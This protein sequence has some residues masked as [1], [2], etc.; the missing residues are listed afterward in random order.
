MNFSVLM[1]VYIKERPEYL[2]SA[3]DSVLKSS[4]T[5]TKIV[6][7]EDGPL[8][9]ELYEVLDSYENVENIKRVPLKKNCGLSV[10][11]NEGIKHIKTDLIARMDT[12]DICREDRFYI[13][14]KEF[15]KHPNLMVLGSDVDEFV[16]GPD[17][18]ISEKNMP[19]G[20][21]EI[22][23]YFKLR[24][25]L[26]HPSV[27]MKSQAVKEV[28][29]YVD[30]PLFE[31]YY[32]W[33]RIIKKYGLNSINNINE[34]LVSMRVVDDLY[35]RRGGLSYAKKSYNFRKTAIKEKLVPPIS[36]FAALISTS[37]VAIMPNLFRKRIYRSVLR[38]D[39]H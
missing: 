34:N 6:I 35:R 12:D 3:V 38:N 36:G 8:T 20:L 15:E 11:L 21:D 13:Q 29:L 31:D 33:L 22:E 10:A 2:R 37:F 16:I 19:S 32:L 1:S 7:V 4:V 24:N 14:V 39:N 25:P 28:G 17:E 26:N 18:I 27:M 30:M 23:K 5:P 9:K